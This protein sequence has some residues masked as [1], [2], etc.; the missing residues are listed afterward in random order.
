[1]VPWITLEPLINGF[2]FLKLG[3]QLK[4]LITEVATLIAGF[5]M[6]K[7]MPKILKPYLG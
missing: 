6:I 5:I 2:K 7:K 4:G 3:K 1:M